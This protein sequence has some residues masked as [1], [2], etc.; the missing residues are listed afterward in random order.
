MKKSF[1]RELE[2]NSKVLNFTNSVTREH[3]FEYPGS[4]EGSFL[5]VAG[6]NIVSVL[7]FLKEWYHDDTIQIKT[8]DPWM[9]EELM[10][11]YI[12]SW[13]ETPLEYDPKHWEEY[14]GIKGDCPFICNKRKGKRGGF[15]SFYE[16]ETDLDG[17]TYYSGRQPKWEFS[18]G[19]LK[20]LKRGEDF[21]FNVRG[22]APVEFAN[23]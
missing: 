14:K 16:C 23:K 7:Q 15:A 9:K 13:E 6:M 19:P 20:G 18:Q 8:G 5:F 3:Y 17:Q 22:W 10:D 21:L 12:N 4:I 11:P 2:N 1:R